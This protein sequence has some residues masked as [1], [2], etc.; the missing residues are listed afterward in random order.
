M[1]ADFRDRFEGAGTVSVEEIG[2]SGLEKATGGVLLEDASLLQ[3]DVVEDGLSTLYRS[4][5][6]AKQ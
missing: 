6:D 1:F 5:W 3:V 4:D 2:R